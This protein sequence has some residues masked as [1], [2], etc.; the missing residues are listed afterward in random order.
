M[1]NQKQDLQKLLSM[2]LIKSFSVYTGISIINAG[3]SFVLFPILTF[4]LST[5]DYGIMSLFLAYAAIVGTLISF[6]VP[7]YTGIHFYDLDK[8]K[9]SEIF[10]SSFFVPIFIFIILEILLVFIY[11]Y[12]DTDIPKIWLLIIPIYAFLEYI[13]QYLLSVLIIM[14]DVKLFSIISILKIVIE[15]S[16]ILLFVIEMNMSWQGKLLS[17]IIVLQ[18]GSIISILF[19]IKKEFLKITFDI[20]III[21]TLAFGAPLILHGLNK[22]VINQ[23]DRIFIS[24]LVSV[25]D[26]G[27]YSAGY[28]I[29]MVV[30][31]VIGAILNVYSP[32]L[33][34]RLS[35]ISEEKKYQILKFSYI[36]ILGL[37]VVFILLNAVVSPLMFKYFINSSFKAG[38]NYVFLISLSYLFWGIYLMFAGY[39]FYLKK[40]KFLAFAAIIIMIINLLLNYVLI[41][42]YGAIGAAQ[43]T[44]ISFFILLVLVM[45]YSSYIYKMPWF[46]INKI[47]NSKI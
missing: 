32:Y 21:K 37:L 12:I 34:E 46:K 36:I 25:E 20:K 19:F 43:S 10:S 45:I 29:G 35:N 22:F 8:N 41:K 23:S 4:Y 30:L 11:N 33:I 2:N 9:Y 38:A 27:L 15:V 13:Y 47:K 16:L 5:S 6:S 28:S 18:L 39:I 3:V 17:S 1:A 7:G 40:T 14:K 24:K 44:A 42:L 26:T 31:I